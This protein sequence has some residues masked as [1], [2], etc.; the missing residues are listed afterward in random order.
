MSS[1]TWACVACGKLYRRAHEIAAPVKCAGCGEP[2]EYVHRKM[3][4]PSPKKAKQWRQ[5]WALYLQEKA[6]LERC[7]RDGTV[8]VVE[9]DLLNMRI[10]PRPGR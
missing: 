8:E 3:R 10:H 1:Q 9:L 7:F 2:C 5:F 6:E 4:V